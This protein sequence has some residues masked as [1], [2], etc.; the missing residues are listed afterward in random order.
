MGLGRG[1][2]IKGL[3]S[4]L[5]PGPIAEDLGYIYRDEGRDEEAI[6]AF[7]LAIDEGPSFHFIYWERADL[8]DRVGEHARAKADRRRARQAA[9]IKVPKAPAT[10]DPPNP[11]LPPDE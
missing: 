8:L 10:Q 7:I 5:G 6:E 11:F 2:S 9:C 4:Y 3:A 1:S